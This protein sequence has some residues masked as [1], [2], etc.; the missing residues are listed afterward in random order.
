MKNIYKYSLFILLF[1]LVSLDVFAQEAII[2]GVVRDK[3]DNQT[4]PMV[5]VVVRDELG[6]IDAKRSTKTGLDGEFSLRVPLGSKVEFSNIGYD[7]VVRKITKDAANLNILMSMSENM[8]EETVVVGFTKKSK[9]E[10]TASV[11]VVEAEDLVNTPVSN[12]LELLQGRVP[13]LNVQL[14]NGTPGGVPSF[15]LRGI[16]DISVSKRG[17]DYVLGSSA[18]LF[19]V[20][21]IPQEDIDKDSDIDAAGLL[22]G[23]TVSPLSMIPFEDIQRMEILKDAAATSLYGSK[24]AYGVILIE[25]KRGN[26]PPRVSYS[27]NYVVKTPPKL[28]DVVVGNAERYL[29]LNQIMQNDTSYYHGH[30]EI[31]LLP[32]LSDSL[33]PYWNNNTDWQGRF[34]DITHNQTHNLSFSGGD[35]KFNY[36]INGNY[37][38]E[39]GIVKNTDF[40]RYGLRTRLGYKP[41]DKFKMDV[42]ISAT[43]TL[44]SQ[45]SGNAFSQSGVAKGSAASSLLPPPSMYTATSSALAA[46]SVDDDNTNTAYDANVHVEYKLPY[47]IL[48]DGTFGYKYNT[49][50]RETFT[51][52]VLNN[53]RSEWYNLS[54]NSYNLYTRA[55][56][57]RTNHIGKLLRIGLQGGVEISSAKSSSNTIRQIGGGSD[58]IWGPGSMPSLSG[59][60]AIFRE[61]ENTLSFI[62]NPSFGLGSTGD[63]GERYVFVPNV[64]PEANS[65]YGRKIKWTINPSLSF[66]WNLSREAFADDW[67]W[68]SS[69]ALRAS[70]GRTTKYKANRYD[71]WGTYKLGNDTYNGVPTIPIDYGLLPNDNLKPVTSTSWNLGL[72]TSFFKNRLRFTGDVYYRQTD[73]QLSDVELADHNAFQRVRSI[74]TS[75]VNYGLEILV[76][77]KPLS[78]QSPW[79]LDISLSLA[80]NK[81]VITK[82]PNESRQIINS[83]AMVVNRLGSNALSNYLLVN[84]GVYAT[85]EDVPVNPAT[86]ERMKVSNNKKNG[87]VY[88]A[89]GDPIWADINGDYI[90]D[91]RDKVVVG[92]SQPRLT[93]GFN[94]NLK[95]KAFS[96][97]TNFSFVMKRDI[98]NA[99]L[100]DRFGAYG[101]PLSQNLYEMGALTPIE[102]YSFWTQDRVNAKYPNPFDYIRGGRKDHQVNFF[103][104]DQTLFMEDGSY[105]KINGISVAY[106]FPKKILEYFNLHRLQLNASVNNIYTFT[107]YSGVNPENVNSLGYDVSGGYP[108]S[109]NYTVGV[110]ID[111]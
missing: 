110:S 7:R 30:N 22:S 78:Q 44:N 6:K 34:Y 11:Q 63:R 2:S 20:D 16:S 49:T 9:A 37:Y 25:T 42:N 52:G 66:R 80:I 59:R 50:E 39:K 21:G 27:G 60:E 15:T 101:D 19:V 70:W 69:A 99:A 93:G 90:I 48:F 111:F 91:D 104:R 73:N 12:A 64:R 65:N 8:L 53:N 5:S 18:P 79:V 76:G 41:N 89:A 57:S 58:F 82:L 13:G 26:G 10:V 3:G 108:N 14:Q 97:N 62:I 88:L 83:D 55:L 35:E 29:R 105:F 47:E 96:I 87:Y 43:I 75:L 67:K 51:P 4:L 17:D 28:R 32:A 46:F 54:Q 106:T 68:L 61:N 31:H 1:V 36:K 95:Y 84:K 100:A 23:A 103:R 85:D 92:N 107:N 98:I 94:I 45:G 33:N 86:G 74:E 72:E 77:G 81:D 71:I 24:G 56:L 40:N 102:S 109:R 38:T